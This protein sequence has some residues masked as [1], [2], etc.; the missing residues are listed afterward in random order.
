VSGCDGGVVFAVDSLVGREGIA[1][2]EVGLGFK[3]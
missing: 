2:R 1:G 3:G